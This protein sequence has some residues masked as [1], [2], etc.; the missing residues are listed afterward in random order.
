[1]PAAGSVFVLMPRD[2][3]DNPRSHSDELIGERSRVRLVL[4]DVRD[5][6]QHRLVMSADAG[7]CSGGVVIPATIRLM[8]CCRQPAV[9]SQDRNHGGEGR[10][11]R[12]RRSP[13]LLVVGQGSHEDW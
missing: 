10:F 8:G 9:L 2:E 1:M 11:G 6:M 12:G 5:L 7:N 4:R 13:P 3:P